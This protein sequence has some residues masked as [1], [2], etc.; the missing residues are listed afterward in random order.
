MIEPSFIEPTEKLRFSREFT[1][2]LWRIARG[3]SDNHNIGLEEA[4]EIMER[5]DPRVKVIDGKV[6]TV[7]FSLYRVHEL[8]LAHRAWK[9]R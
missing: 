2:T 4:Y 5:V 9:L 7:S 8:I 1:A 6:K 3:I